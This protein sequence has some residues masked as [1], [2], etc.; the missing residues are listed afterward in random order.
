M[1][2]LSRHQFCVVSFVQVKL[3]Q[4]MKE[5]ANRHKEIE[6]KRTREIAQLR[7]ESRKRENEIRTLQMDK[8]VKETVLKRKQEEV[9][10]LR[11]VQAR[12]GVLSD[13]ASGRVVQSGRNSRKPRQPMYS[14]KVAKQKWHKLEHNL[15]QMAL[16]RLTVSQLEKDLERLM[17]VRDELGRSLSET[18]RIRDR[19]FMRG[20]EESYIRELD[21]QLE[22]LKANI[23]Y[24]QENI[25][26]CQ[27]N[28]VQI[29]E[30]KVKIQFVLF[31][32]GR[33]LELI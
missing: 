14:P 26:E 32:P 28:I 16:N 2:F 30:T 7:K 17:G 3:M 10:A 19:A 12:Q 11:K 1:I 5:D 22:S 4:K 8:R 9:N 21:D 29:E 31:F 23:E 18:L 13:R 33:V 15:S 20:K 24:V 6:L 25:A 27:R